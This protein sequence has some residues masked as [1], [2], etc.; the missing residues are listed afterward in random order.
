MEAKRINRMEV[1]EETHREHQLLAAMGPHRLVWVEV[2]SHREGV[3]GMMELAEEV[4]HKEP[5]V[6]IVGV[7]IG[8]DLVVGEEIHDEL[9]VAEIDCKLEL[10]VAE[11][12]GVV[13][14]VQL[15][16]VNGEKVEVGKSRLVVVVVLHGELVGMGR[17]LHMVEGTQL[18]MLVEVVTNT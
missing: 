15:V 4:V 8:C 18:V 6:V 3:V 12:A 11:T 1:E 16:V 10:V 7:E 13:N 5:V 17:A 2:G 9:E 14:D